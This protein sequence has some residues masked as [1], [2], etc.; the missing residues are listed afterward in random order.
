MRVKGEGECDCEGEGEGEGEPLRLRLRLRL[1]VRVLPGSTHRAKDTLAFGAWVGLVVTDG[2][3]QLD[4]P[5]SRSRERGE[6]GAL[7]VPSNGVGDGMSLC[8]HHH[9]H[10]SQGRDITSAWWWHL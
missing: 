3:E 2:S 6:G 5:S 9:R 1:R 7:A 4:D 10:W 8:M